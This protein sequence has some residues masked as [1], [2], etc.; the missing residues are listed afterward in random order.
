MYISFPVFQMHSFLAG[1]P[2][3]LYQVYAS[4]HLKLLSLMLVNSSQLCQHEAGGEPTDTGCCW[5]LILGFNFSWLSERTAEIC[6]L[7]Q[8]DLQYETE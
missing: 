4:L 7:S 3:L 6:F 1:G 8:S 5:L 2:I